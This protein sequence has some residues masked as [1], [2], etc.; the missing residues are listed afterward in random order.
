M[1]LSIE[2]A[3]RTGVFI[4]GLSGDLAARKKGP[5]GMTAQDIL[6]TLPLAVQ[7]YRKNLD[8]ISADYYQTAYLI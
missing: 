7:Y 6:N 8:A 2:A 3:V 1:G 5:D 4:H